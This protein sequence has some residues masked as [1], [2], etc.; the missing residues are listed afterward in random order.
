[1]S[2]ILL[3]TEVKTMDNVTDENK[4]ESLEDLRELKR[5]FYTVVSDFY[6]LQPNDSLS[7]GLLE[8]IK[9]KLIDL[10][11]EVNAVFHVIKDMESG[12]Q[13]KQFLRKTFSKFL[14][15]KYINPLLERM[16]DSLIETKDRR[17]RRIIVEEAQSIKN[18]ILPLLG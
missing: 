6:T 14:L 17:K 5:D 1:M 11:A 9:P 16:N 15:R 12:V 3:K 7:E 18:Q 8:D 13:D 10:G 4:P 2:D